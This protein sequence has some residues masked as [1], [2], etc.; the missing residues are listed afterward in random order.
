MDEEKIRQVEVALVESVTLSS[1][2]DIL[3]IGVFEDFFG[4]EGEFTS[5]VDLQEIDNAL[6]GLLSDLTK[7]EEFTGKVGKHVV[8]RVPGK[9]F[10]RIALVGLGKIENAGVG[11]SWKAFG[12]IIASLAKQSKASSAAVSVIGASDLP[13]DSKKAAL[14]GLTSGLPFFILHDVLQKKVV[15]SSS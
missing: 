14:G 15:F 8:A 1:D 9:S 2:A 13:I 5:S 6:N 7:E 3:L 12:G 11:G 10:K 4:K